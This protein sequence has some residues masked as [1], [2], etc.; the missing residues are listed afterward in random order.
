ML[1][2]VYLVFI[3]IATLILLWYIPQEHFEDADPCAGLTDS[4]IASS[5]PVSCIQKLVRD[6]GCSTTGSI[7]PPNASWKGWYNTAPNGNQVV[8]CDGAHP[9]PNCGAGNLG[10]VKADIHAWAT[11]FDE[12][13]VKGCMGQQCR[14]ASTPLDA[15]GGGNAV[16]LDRQ[17]VRCKADESLL[18]FKLMRNGAGNQINYYYVCCKNQGP[19]G[20]QGPAGPAGVAGKDG[21]PGTAGAPGPAGISGAPGPAGPQGPQGIAGPQGPAGPQGVTP[22]QPAPVIADQASFLTS[23]QDIFRKEVQNLQ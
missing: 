1:I 20:A 11:M 4:T 12:V 23:F 5:I 21:A 6:E 19:A 2:T 18:R 9:Y 3:V 8:Y 13:H 7:Y 16:Y 14:I 15:D 10:V 17:D 22:S